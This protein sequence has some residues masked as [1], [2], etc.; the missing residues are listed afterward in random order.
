MKTTALTVILLLLL[1]AGSALPQPSSNS[2]GLL[3]GTAWYP[4]Q[5]PEERWD[6]DLALM[7]AAGIHVVR[8]AEFAWSTMEPSEGSYQ[9]DWLQRAIRLAARHHI[10]VILGTPTAAPPAWLTQKYPDTLLIDENGKRAV[11]GNRQQFSFTSSRYR[12]FC[13]KIA[14]AMAKQLA[15]EPNVIGWQLDN[16]ISNMSYDDYTR[17]QFQQWL[18]ARYKTLDSL[19]QHWT[20]TYWSQTYSDW[21]QIPIP[22]GPNNPGLMLE[23]MRFV[24]DT[25]REYLDNQVRAIRKYAPAREP[26]CTNTMGTFDGFDHYNVE[27]ILDIAAWDNYVGEGHLTPALGFTH[28]LTRGFK[29]K[30]YWVIETQPGAVNWAKVNNTLD[31]GE[32]RA[33]AWQDIAHGADLVSYWQWRSALNGQEEYHGTLVGADGTPVPLYEEIQQIGHDFAKA[34]PI[35]AGTA[36]H[37]EIA[38]LFDYDSRWAIDWQKFNDNYD[39]IK[40]DESVYVALRKLTQTMDVVRPTA[41][42]ESYKVVVAPNLSLIPDALAK[43]LRE[44][45]ENGGHLVLGPRSGM[46]DEYNA[47]LPQRQ[48]GALGEL[49][50][51]RV[52][53]FYALESAI[54]VTGSLG[55]GHAALWAELLSARQSDAEVPLKY[56]K[57]NGWLDDQPAIVSRKVGKGRITYVGAVLD[58]ALLAKLAEWIA[59]TSGIHP[60]FGPVPEG[61]EVAER[62]AQGK[63]VFILINLSGS[64][65][66]IKLPRSMHR[67]LNSAEEATSVSLPRYGVEVLQE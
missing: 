46:K 35:L 52:E 17:G 10:D 36:P 14:E 32:V 59:S 21:S 57:S 24:S 51:G 61:I 50:G 13:R 47:L 40:V 44:Y 31:K 53:Q 28:D 3:L 64:D 19:N 66:N 7:E 42:L 58:D 9:L 45:V 48:P 39:S 1:L 29:Q 33:M 26:I 54:P 4:E 8:V 56:G 43:H 60:A 41:A 55:D 34:G 62:S 63:N 5:W 65:Q 11:H 25:W 23:W 15:S 2:P 38:M 18:R 6:K 67:V 20:T 37:S 12:E 30:N 16:E 49:L 27:Q 22:V